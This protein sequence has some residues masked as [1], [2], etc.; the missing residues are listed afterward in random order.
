MLLD[1]LMMM[2]SYQLDSEEEEDILV[3]H[4]Q[5]SIPLVMMGLATFVVM[6]SLV[7]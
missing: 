6:K 5:Y 1:V 4:P 7:N 3:K 2:G